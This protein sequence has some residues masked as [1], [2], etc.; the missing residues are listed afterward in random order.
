MTILHLKNTQQQLNHNNGLYR[1]R[2]AIK[3]Q[4]S[5]LTIVKRSKEVRIAQELYCRAPSAHNT[6]RGTTSIA[7]EY[8][9]R[10]KLIDWIIQNIGNSN[11]IIIILKSDMNAMLN[12][13]EFT[14]CSPRDVTPAVD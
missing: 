9:S 3:Q 1:Q 2:I 5:K 13:N 14:S 12:I 6:H 11:I 10:A 7:Q 8:L 4:N